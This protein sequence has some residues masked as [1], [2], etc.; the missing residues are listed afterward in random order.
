[1]VPGLVT[2]P[3][4]HIDGDIWELRPL[5][6]RIFFFYWKD[7]TFVLLHYFHKKT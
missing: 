6:D 3:V 4:K 5:A 2:Q 7:N 1:M